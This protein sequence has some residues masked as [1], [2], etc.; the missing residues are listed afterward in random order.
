M[1]QQVVIANSELE[2]LLVQRDASRDYAT[3]LLNGSVTVVCGRL[4]VQPGTLQTDYN[5]ADKR[6]LEE[7]LAAQMSFYRAVRDTFARDTYVIG[8]V[9]AILAG[10]TDIDRINDSEVAER[11][12]RYAKLHPAPI[13]Q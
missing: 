4:P 2:G 9:K 11:D 3:Q 1:T 13:P 5:H 6:D 10:E 12:A 8:A 7:C